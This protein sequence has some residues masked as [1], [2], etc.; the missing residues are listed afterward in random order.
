MSTVR[1]GLVTIGQSPRPD[2]RDTYER[3]LGPAV[4]V[5]EAGA[6]DDLAAADVTRLVPDRGDVPLVTLFDGDEVRIGKQRVT[7]LLQRAIHRVVEGGATIVVVL[8]TGHF[9]GLRARVPLIEPDRVLDG[10][11]RA[12][13]PTG[14]LGIVMPDGGQ[15]AMMRR[16]WRGYDLTLATVSP[17]Q[18]PATW[19]AAISRFTDAGA[20]GIVLDC[21]GFG[22][23]AKAYFATHSGVP[24]LCAQTA[25][26][27]LVRDLVWTPTPVH[28]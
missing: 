27:H 23:D 13:Q 19:D 18:L 2:M 9:D 4:Q 7:P 5:V 21:M 1:I 22:P 24:V 15:E 3:I 14:S 11:M 20:E 8:C 28:A 16:K 12:I 6:L 10:F 17:Y 26:A 25:T